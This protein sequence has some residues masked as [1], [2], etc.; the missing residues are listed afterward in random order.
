MRHAWTELDRPRT[1]PELLLPAPTPTP[2]PTPTPRPTPISVSAALAGAPPPFPITPTLPEMRGIV[3]PTLDDWQLVTSGGARGAVFK[4][5]LAGPAVE[6]IVQ[7]GLSVRLDAA[8]SVS[9][10][11]QLAR[12]GLQLESGKIYTLTFA[13]R[14]PNGRRISVNLWETR[15][16]FKWL[17]VKQSVRITDD[18]GFYQLAFRPVGAEPGFVRL[19]F[20]LGNLPGSVQLGA[21]SLRSGGHLAA[22]ANWS[23]RGNLPLVDAQDEPVFAVRRDFAR[24]LGELETKHTLKWRSFLRGDLKVRV[25]IWQTQAQ[26]GGWGGALRERDSDALDIHVYWKHPEFLGAA[27]DGTNWRVGNQ[28]MAA[29]P[30]SDPLVAYSL[31]RNAG[32]PL[33]VTEWNSG[34]P[35]D[36]GAETLLMAASHAAHQGWAGVWMFDY[37]S[38]GAW[39]RTNFEGFFSIDSNPVKMATAPLAALLFRRGD[40]AT[41]TNGPTLTIPAVRAWD[42]LARAPFGP[43]MQPFVKTWSQ[44]G[45]PRDAALSERTGWTNAPALFPTPSRSSLDSENAP[46]FDTEMSDTGEITRDDRGWSL[47]TPRAKAFAGFFGGRRF[48]WGEIEAWFPASNSAQPTW[49]AGGVAAM[50]DQPIATSKR[51]LLVVC[52]RAE[53]LNMGWNAARDSV[54][55]NW[56]QGPTFV[57][58]PPAIWKVR[59]DAPEAHVWALDQ[60]G[61]RR[62]VIPSTLHDG[63]LK[64]STSDLWRSPWYEIALGKTEKTD[65]TIKPGG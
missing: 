17:G 41:S 34:Q 22:P 8:G 32:K 38:N 47:D 48:K 45:M 42:E 44:T 56:G 55:G 58:S 24:Y 37:H 49:A 35:N 25:P 26:F 59:T 6:G 2:I 3:A 4:D 15:H 62:G 64:F 39:S 52:G 33:V 40:V 43:T 57:A 54:G 5:E 36:Y 12:D 31:A 63:A 11:F 10:G 46:A 60:R 50:D 65:A 28:S 1:G 19:A 51:L 29:S 9:W 16:P 61:Q 7:P 23:L 13:A 30:D 21:L 27:W 20:D 14:S 18:W 53:N